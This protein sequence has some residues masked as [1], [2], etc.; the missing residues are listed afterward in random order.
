LQF[1]FELLQ[2]YHLTQK[3]D[4]LTRRFANRE[5]TTTRGG[6]SFMAQAQRNAL[7]ASKAAEFK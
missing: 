5:L 1:A 6:F 2:I 7:S 4:V 3:N